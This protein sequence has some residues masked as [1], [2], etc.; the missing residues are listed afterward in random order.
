MKKQQAGF[1]LIELMIVVAIIGILA[2][3]AIPSYMDYTKKAAVAEVLNMTA[4]YKLGIADELGAGTAMADLGDATAVGAPSFSPTSKVSGLTIT[5]GVITVT[6]NATAIGDLEI[7]LEPTTS[8]SGITWDC[9]ASG[10]DARLAP[11]SCR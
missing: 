1:T 6:A 2:A 5:A 3:I 7:E 9:T 8:S 10:E 4:P 11:A